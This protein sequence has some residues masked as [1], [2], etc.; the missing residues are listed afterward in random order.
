MTITYCKTCLYPD[1]KPDLFIDEKDICSACR[2][3]EKRKDIDWNARANEFVQLVEQNR[4]LSYDCIVPVSGGKDS[5]YQIIK[6]KDLGFNPLAVTATTCDLSDIGRRNLDNIGKLGVDHIEVTPDRVQRREM[7]RLGLEMVGDISWAEHLAIF[8][9][10]VRVAVQMGIK[11]IIYG[12]C[13]QN[14]YGGPASEANTLDRRW[15][16]EY[17][18]LIGMRVT[19]L[20]NVVPPLYVYPS[21]AELEHVGVTSLFLGHYFPWDGYENAQIAQEHGLEFYKGWV[22]GS[23]CEFENLDNHQ[24]GIHDWFKFLKFGFGR[25]TDIACNNIR[26]GRWA[27]NEAMDIIAMHDGA[28]PYTYLGKSL[29]DILAEIDMDRD[30]FFKIAHQFRNKKLVD[31]NWMKIHPPE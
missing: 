5:H 30:S 17:G 9:I 2:S 22:E 15:L 13:P 11:L 8:T 18:G 14:E 23:V 26:R 25:A 3:F 16:E 12:E 31:E 27:R 20:F 7:N 4:S 19:D 6:L 24:T 29:D 1:T 28:V 10:P 21:E